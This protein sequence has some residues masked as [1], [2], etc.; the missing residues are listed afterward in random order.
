MKPTVDNHPPKQHPLGNKGEMENR[1]KFQIIEQKNR[2][3]LERLAT[4]VQSKTIDNELDDIT[5]LHIKFVKK[6]SVQ[7]KRQ[8]MKKVTDSNHRLL[9]RIQECPPEY[10]HLEWEEEA[11][12]RENVLR[13]IA[14]YPEYYERLDEEKKKS[15]NTKSQES[16]W[17]NLNKSKSASGFLPPI[18]Y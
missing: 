2:E 13:I 11:K 8:E 17:N 1:R 5:N 12:Q 7:K 18:K 14:Q 16:P 6:N 10:N 3:L 9:R 4:I 15:R